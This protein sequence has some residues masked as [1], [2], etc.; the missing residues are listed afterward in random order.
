LPREHKERF[1]PDPRVIEQCY[2]LLDAAKKGEL[3]ALAYCTVTHDGLTEGAQVGCGW[4]TSGPATVY[5]VTHALGVLDRKWA[6]YCD[7][8]DP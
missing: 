8:G 7:E 6:K 2:V 5:A 4:A 1:A 3:R